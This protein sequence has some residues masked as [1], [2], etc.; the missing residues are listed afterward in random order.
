MSPHPTQAA[1]PAATHL[2]RL[3]RARIPAELAGRRLDQAL[4][5]LFPAYSRSRIQQWIREG[6]VRLEGA[7]PRP[8]DPVAEGQAVE[9]EAVLE[10]EVPWRGEAL[11][12]DLA[13]E[14]ADLLVVRKP[15]GLVVHP[16]PGHRGGTLVN[17][18]LHHAP[19]LERLPRAGVVHRLDKDTSGLLVVARTPLAHRALV[20]QLQR[21]EVE[22][23]Y[24]ALASGV[25]VAGGTVSAPIGR[26]PVR[27]QRMAVVPGGREAVT[28][29]R[30]LERYRAHTRLE[31]RLETGRTHQIRVH[32]AHLG[33]PLVG[34]PV[35]GGRP[36]PPR[37]A[38]EA[39]LGAL[40]GF[41][42][43]ALH[44]RVLGLLHPRTGERL[45][46]EWEPPEDFRA[47]VEA[48]RR[49]LREAGG[50]DG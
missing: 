30:V 48:L 33:H 22:R 47:L 50:D 29:Y 43:Q 34:D 24:E 20:A 49:D 41:R 3:H 13:Y 45:R 7:R 14:D 18:L 5:A 4:A 46:W 16:A 42:R 36:R 2:R 1:P 8:R 39:L 15:A 21:R 44:A 40:R 26:H 17:A 6:R 32:L 10:T 27:R 19:E 9:L 38:G 11:A 31:L 12:L 25:L 37:G 35:Y 23:R 28:H